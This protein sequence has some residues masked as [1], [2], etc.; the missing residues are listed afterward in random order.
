MATPDDAEGLARV[1]VVAWQ[2]AYRG[3]L[4]DDFLA[5]LTVQGRREQWD[6]LLA[7]STTSPTTGA[8]TWV[9]HDDGAV[10]GF[11]S[12]GPSR[13][14][15][16]SPTA[17]ELY[18]IYVRPDLVGTG[19]GHRLLDE[20]LAGAPTA[21]VTLWVLEGNQTARRFYERAGF[22]SD[23]ATKNDTIGGRDVVELR[24]RRAAAGG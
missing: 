3:L 21:D 17:W 24:Y 20:A 7:E 23:G 5:G 22:S 11:A 9:A 13:D 16:E 8:G 6:H 18:G 2:S 14:E 12:A 4:D 1:H 15:D 10:V 19:V